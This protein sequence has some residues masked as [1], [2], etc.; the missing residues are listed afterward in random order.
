M[1]SLLPVLLAVAICA[2]LTAEEPAPQHAEPWTR[3]VELNATVRVAGIPDGAG[4]LDLWIP[5]PMANPYQ[6][7][8]DVKIE[9]PYPYRLQHDA[10][11][12][13]RMIYLSIADPPKSFDLNMRFTVRRLENDGGTMGTEGR[14]DLPWTLDAAAL[15]PISPAVEALARAHIEN[16][17]SIRDQ[18]YSLYE[19]TMEYMTYDKT[20]EGW[21]NGDWQYACDHRKGNCS[22]FHSYFI[23]LCRNIGIPA[24]FEIGYSIPAGKSEGQITGY[25]CWAY[26]WDGRHW[27]PVD[28]SEAD[29]HPEKAVYFFGHHDPNRVAFTRGRDITLTPPQ[30]GS[31]LN[32]FIYPYAE[33]DGKAYPGV[34]H[35]L[36]FREI[37][38]L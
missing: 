13:N 19:H 17:G 16:G 11:Y 34:E 21:G 33:V 31:P 12:G 25:H 32:F 1:R 35:T 14:G 27:A 20:G 4:H 18:A 30:K 22:D 15:I 29:K 6:E 36:T 8:L 9:S 38:N 5:Y 3:T 24:Y 26:F 23:G 2:P 7:V 37:T 28:I 10:K